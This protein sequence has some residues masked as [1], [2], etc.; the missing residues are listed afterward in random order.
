MRIVMEAIRDHRHG[1]PA[2][3][4]TEVAGMSASF[5]VSQPPDFQALC[6]ALDDEYRARA[7]YRAVIGR[8]G[9]VL[10]FANIVHAEQRHIDTLLGLFSARGWEAPADRWNANVEPPETVAQACRA[11]AEA[12]RDNVALYDRITAQAS[13]PEILA[14]FTSLRAASQERHLPAFLRHIEGRGCGQRHAVP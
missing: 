10:P 7:T 5:P 1:G 13:D 8:F 11:G 14:A 2:P 3:F 9:P 4:R 12:E 6:E